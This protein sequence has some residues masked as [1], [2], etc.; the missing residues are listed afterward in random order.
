M[1]NKK[2]KTETIATLIDRDGGEI[3]TGPFGTAL[4]AREY[5]DSGTPVVAVRDIGYGRLKPDEKTPRIPENVVSRLSIYK[6][7]EGDI[8]FGRKGAVDRS[9]LIRIEE[10]GWLMG[11][12]C[13]RL[14]LPKSID[15]RFINYCFQSN[16]HRVWMEQQ[17]TG[18]TMPSLNQL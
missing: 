5:T 6:L 13:I 18:S 7:E 4:N 14:R 3:R 9:A 11:S 17:A 15:S 8:L 12:D 1:A 16:S 10:S 2:L